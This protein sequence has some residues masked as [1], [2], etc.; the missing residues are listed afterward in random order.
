[1]TDGALLADEVVYLKTQLQDKNTELTAAHD[2]L[3]AKTDYIARLEDK[4]SFDPYAIDLRLGYLINPVSNFNVY[5][6]MFRRDYNSSETEWIYFGI[7]TSLT[8]YYY[9]F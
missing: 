1:M 7:K 5:V 8:N 4:G 3:K 9:D 2:R 6:G